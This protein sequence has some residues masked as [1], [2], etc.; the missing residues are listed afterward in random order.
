MYK[1]VF[2]PNFKRF[3][4]K[5]VQEAEYNGIKGVFV[6]GQPSTIDEDREAETVGDKAFDNQSTADYL[7]NPI[8][9]FN[10]GLDNIIGKKALGTVVEWK[11]LDNG[12]WVKA[13]IP[14]PEWKPMLDIYNNIVSGVLKSFSIGGVFERIKQQGKT[15]INKIHLFEISVEPVQANQNALFEV[16]TKAFDYL[17]DEQGSKAVDDHHITEIVDNR[18][19]RDEMWRANDAMM[20]AIRN[21]L[22]DEELDVAGRKESMNNILKE[23]VAIVTKIIN[24]TKD[25]DF[26][27]LDLKW[28]KFGD[29]QVSTK[30]GRVLSKAN[31]DELNEVL[32]RVTAIL[33]KLKG[34]TNVKKDNGKEKE[35]EKGES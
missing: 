5:E 12:P 20:E 16:A 8:I 17:K 28:I 19:V 27:A 32:K 2:V 14:K 18:K 31:E 21:I 24:G 23:Y 33:A 11:M 1:N 10:H 22:K 26:E 30:A 25:F 29:D 9:L 13:F 3:D 15:I 4:I 7:K 34:S 35:K 6:Q